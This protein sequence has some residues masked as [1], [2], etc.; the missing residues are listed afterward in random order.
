MGC[1]VALRYL[2]YC[3]PAALERHYKGL[4]FLLCVGWSLVFSG[5][6]IPLGANCEAAVS[7]GSGVHAS[8][9]VYQQLYD[10]WNDSTQSIG[11]GFSLSLYEDLH[12]PTRRRAIFLGCFLVLCFLRELFSLYIT[13]LLFEGSVYRIRITTYSQHCNF[14]ACPR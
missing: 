9:F 12:D 4:I 7:I 8:A 3:H 5:G 1:S 10:A 6:Y 14:F 11:A 13:R 2:H